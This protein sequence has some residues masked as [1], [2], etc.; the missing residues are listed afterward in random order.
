ME[1]LPGV[2]LTS[3]PVPRKLLVIELLP[4]ELSR[5][6]LPRGLPGELLPGELSRRLLPRDLP[7]ELLPGEL[8][9]RLLPRELLPGE[10][11]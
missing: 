6:L 1:L 7:G 3:A 5:R 8:S 2:L 9:R 11:S 4:G 10:L